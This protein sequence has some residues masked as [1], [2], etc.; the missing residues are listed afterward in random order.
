MKITTWLGKN[1]LMQLEPRQSS[2][3]EGLRILK[4]KSQMLKSFQ[5]DSLALVHNYAT[6]KT[7]SVCD[8]VGSYTL[9]L[10]LMRDPLVKSKKGEP[11]TYEPLSSRTNFAC[12]KANPLI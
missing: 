5:L 8:M 2:P 10:G 11:A 1:V 3:F 7:G 9:A 4:V 6:H 12:S